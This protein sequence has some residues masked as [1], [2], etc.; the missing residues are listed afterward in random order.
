[1]VPRDDTW[2]Q[3]ILELREFGAA[4]VS[5]LAVAAGATDENLIGCDHCGLWSMVH[6]RSRQPLPSVRTLEC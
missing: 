2:D 1:M 5:R 4:H 6:S 3:L